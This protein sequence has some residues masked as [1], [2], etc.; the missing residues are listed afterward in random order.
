[1]LENLILIFNNHSDQF[2]EYT[3][4]LTNIIKTGNISFMYFYLSQLFCPASFYKLRNGIILP[5]LSS[6]DMIYLSIFIFTAKFQVLDFFQYQFS[7]I[8]I[9]PSKR[10]KIVSNYPLSLPSTT[11]TTAAGLQPSLLCRQLFLHIPNTSPIHVGSY[12]VYSDMFP[13]LFTCPCHP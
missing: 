2:S 13:S 1:M 6:V 5:F 3:F 10:L 9:C 12:S 4:A 8:L 7:G 11:G